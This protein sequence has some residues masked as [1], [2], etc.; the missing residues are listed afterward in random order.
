[1]KRRIAR[2]RHIGGRCEEYSFS[3]EA[4]RLKRGLALSLGAHGATYYI[5]SMMQI[6]L[7]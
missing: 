6:L 2:E 1:M 3:A 5:P 4:R 7:S